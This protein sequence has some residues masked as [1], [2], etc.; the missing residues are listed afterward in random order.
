MLT[1]LSLRGDV[2]NPYQIHN[3]EKHIFQERFCR[4]FTEDNVD[5]DPLENNN[6]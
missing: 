6:L 2:T 1:F 3:I 4:K 5:V